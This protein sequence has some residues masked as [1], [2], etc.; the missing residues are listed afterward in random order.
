MFELAGNSGTLST[1]WISNGWKLR[2][3][4][5]R[6]GLPGMVLGHFHIASLD[7]DQRSGLG[8][9]RPVNLVN[10]VPVIAWVFDPVRVNPPLPS[11]STTQALWLH[12]VKG[13]LPEVRL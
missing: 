12:Q 7:P 4:D 6:S 8:K 11:T 10:N 9:S 3:P 13:L 1:S 2:R 5:K